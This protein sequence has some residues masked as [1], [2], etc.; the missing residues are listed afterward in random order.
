MPTIFIIISVILIWTTAYTASDVLGNLQWILYAAGAVALS[1]IFW[2]RHEQSAAS[3]RFETERDVFRSEK[4]AFKEEAEDFKQIKKSFEQEIEKRS[5]LIQKRENILSQ[6]LITL[7]EWMEFPRGIDESENNEKDLVV[8]DFHKQDQAVLELL[9]EQTD[10]L[11]KRIKNNYYQENGLFQKDRLFN[12]IFTLVDKIARIYNPESENPVLETSIEQLLRS[13]NRTALH[14]LVLMEQLPLDFKTYNLKKTFETVQAGVKAYSVYKNAMPYWDYLR[15]VYYLGRFTLG[16]SPITIGVGWALGELAKSGAQKISSHIADRYALNLLYDIVFIIGNEAAG[17]FG[18]DFRHREANWIYGA[19]LTE[20]LKHFPSSRE[21]LKG[22]LNEIG[23][24]CLRNEYDRIFLYRC[25]AANKSAGPENFKP[26]SF[27]SF[28]ERQSVAKKLEKF[29]IKLI[30]DKKNCA[31]PESWKTKFEDR[32]GVKL[33]MNTEIFS[34]SFQEKS[35]DCLFSLAG[36]LMSVK[37]SRGHD[38]PGL[39]S[40][41]RIITYADEKLR[42]ETIQKLIDEPPMIFDYPDMEP[43]DPLLDDYI[44]DLIYLCVRTFPFDGSHKNIVEQVCGYFRYKK[45][46]DVQTHIDKIYCDF[47]TEKLLPESPEKKLKPHD[48]HAISAFF[49]AG[50]TLFFIYKN[51]YIEIPEDQKEK[52]SNIKDMELWLTGT[53]LR[54]MLLALPEKK[55]DDKTESLLIWQAIKKTPEQYD[56]YAEQ[57]KGRIKSDCRISGG[58]WVLEQIKNIVPSPFLR[59]SGHTITRYEKYFKLICQNQDIHLK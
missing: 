30:A 4:K 41:T 51:I 44:F 17:I 26:V 15:P 27:I 49:D 55:K 6:K 31:V 11:F 53:S 1:G 2:F 23:Q 56:F 16:A 29:W 57:I 20:M 5:L 10:Q 48:A 34:S 21:I 47:I 12:D 13:I 14:I 45:I 28:E 58:Q 18:G 46:K 39:L 50:E 3:I 42:R 25:I 54:V 33:C 22:G 8:K 35:T 9:K 36:F 43:S 38:L 37:K 40:E 24:L 52:I 59:L 19:E 7:H 32:M